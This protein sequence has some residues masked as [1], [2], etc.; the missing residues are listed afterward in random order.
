M[1]AD[2]MMYHA[3]E[4]G[5]NSVKL[6]NQED[7]EVILNEKQHKSSLLSTAIE[8]DQIVPFFQPIQ[9]SKNNKNGVVIHELLMRIQ[10]DDKLISAYEFIEIA[11]MMGLINKMDLMVI[12]KAFQKIN[13]TNYQGILFINLS[14][15]SLVVSDFIAKIN[16]LVEEYHIDKEKIVFEI[17]ERETVKNFSL[18]E[19]F[20]QN[21]KAEGFKFAID[22][23]GSGFS[24]FH[25]IKKFP[26]DY[27]KVDGDFIININNDH[28]DK[29]FVHSIV[30]LA[31]ELNI[32][33]IAEFV[34]SEEI[35][36]ILDDM[37]VDYYQGYHIG[38]PN[39][40]FMQLK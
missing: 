27:L 12:K 4:E 31:Q 37:G 17:T 19:K 10:Q 7:I 39:Q 28:K 36:E 21:L 3:K 38:K 18:L 2:S 15:K 29:A 22:D 35:V 26:I 13:E 25:Y 34:E 20:V 14:P 11:E 33:T 24:S 23:F 5:K 9:M 8:N 40:E 6:A 30:T 16:N 1:I 32:Q